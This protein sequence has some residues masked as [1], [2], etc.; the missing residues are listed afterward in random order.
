MSRIAYIAEVSST[1]ETVTVSSQNTVSGSNS[2]LP[3]VYTVT[4]K[5][6][7]GV[8]DVPLTWIKTLGSESSPPAKATLTD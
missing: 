8:S 5:G 3:Y 6:R 4:W 7:C 1:T 2:R